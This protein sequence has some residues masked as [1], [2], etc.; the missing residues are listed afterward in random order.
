MKCPLCNHR[1]KSKN[2][3]NAHKATVH[4]EEKDKVSCPMCAK[5]LKSKLS[6]S[7]HLHKVCTPKGEYKCE[8]CNYKTNRRYVIVKHFNLFHMNGIKNS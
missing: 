2:N 8:H 7:E 5:T 3:L 4:V 6:L 1:A